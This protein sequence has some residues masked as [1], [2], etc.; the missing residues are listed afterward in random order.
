MFRH[1]YIKLL[2]LGT[3]NALENKFKI[4]GRGQVPRLAPPGDTH[5]SVVSAK[6]KTIVAIY[7]GLI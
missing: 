6:T 2:Q 5:E 1:I 4:L 3:N 7:M